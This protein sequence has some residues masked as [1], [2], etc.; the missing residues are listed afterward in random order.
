MLTNA[1]PIPGLQPLSRRILIALS[2]WLCTAVILVLAWFFFNGKEDLHMLYTA[3]Q[4]LRL[5]A[6]PAIIDEVDQSGGG[7]GL[8]YRYEFQGREYRGHSFYLHELGQGRGHAPLPGA[9]QEKLLAAQVQETP[10]TAWVHPE[11]PAHAV[12][13]KNFAWNFFLSTAPLPILLTILAALFAYA[14]V[15]SLQARKAAKWRN[16]R[17][18]IRDE[19]NSPEMFL[20]G[21][22]VALILLL[23]LTYLYLQLWQADLVSGAIVIALLGLIFLFSIT[24]TCLELRKH[25]QLGQL[26]LQLYCSDGRLLGRLHSARGLGHS[27]QVSDPGLIPFEM[28]LVVQLN[29]DNGEDSKL[30]DVWQATIHEGQAQQGCTHID[31]QYEIPATIYIPAPEFQSKDVRWVILFK[32]CDRKAEFSIP[33]K[34]PGMRV[35]RAARA[36]VPA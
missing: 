31:F 1:L 8:R 33:D 20:I 16:N 23:I 17:T 27:G 12:L 19:I 5:Q 22:I 26:Q 18:Y 2:L 11:R 21:A 29:Q 32:T 13:E 9:A 36:A 3:A 25:K 28:I 4:S 24:K 14:G 7:K 10:V 35:R 6:T 30:E 34:L 15:K